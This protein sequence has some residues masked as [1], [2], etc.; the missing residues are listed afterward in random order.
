MNAA[1]SDVEKVVVGFVSTVVVD[2]TG[3]GPT[4]VLSDAT[5][6][7]YSAPMV[8]QWACSPCGKNPLPWIHIFHEKGDSPKGNGCDIVLLVISLALLIL[9]VSLVFLSLLPPCRGLTATLPPTKNDH[10]EVD[11]LPETWE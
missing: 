8:A 6:N 10:A 4:R 5:P 1:D 2:C 3:P 7:L 11:R 9:L